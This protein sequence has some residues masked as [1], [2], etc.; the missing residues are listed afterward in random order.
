MSGGNELHPITGLQEKSAL[1]LVTHRFCGIK[2]F[3]LRGTDN[4]PSTRRIHAIDS[5]MFSTDC[6]RTRCNF[7]PG[8]VE[9]RGAELMMQI[10][11]VWKSR[12]KTE[13][14]Y[15]VDWCSVVFDELV[16]ANLIVS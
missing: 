10:A 6:D 15:F 12:R 2:N 14:V 9:S 11:Q 4:V 7:Q 16:R 8:R 5:G 13:Q 3:Y 1:L